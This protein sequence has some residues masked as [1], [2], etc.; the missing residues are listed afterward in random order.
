M[1]QAEPSLDFFRRLREHLNRDPDRVAFQILHPAGGKEEVSFRRVGREVLALADYLVAQGVAEA[2]RV[3]VILENHPRWG[4]AFLAIQSI[5]GV[6][7][8]LDV[9]HQPATLARLLEHSGCRFVISSE[10]QLETLEGVLARLPKPLPVLIHGSAGGRYPEWDREAVAD[11]EDWDRLPQVARDPDSPHLIMYTSGTTGDPKGVVLT[12]RNLYRNVIEA[13]KIIRITP[14]DHFLGVLPLYH[15]LALEVNFVAALYAGA[16][17]SF[18]DA[19]DAPSILKAFREEGVTVF[20]CVPQFFYMLHRRIFNE[21]E[22]RGWAARKVF[23]AMMKLS[24]LSWRVLGYRLGRRL[25]TPV[26]A[27]FGPLRL[28]GVGGARFDPE[29]ARELTDLGFTVAQA[30][31]MTET[32]A[33]ATLAD[34]R[35]RGIGS[36]GAPLAHVEIRIDRPDTG[37]VGEV[38]IRGENIMEGYYR[39]PDATAAAIRDGWLHSGDLGRMDRHGYLYITGRA[40]DVIVLSSGKNIYPEEVEHFYQSQCPLIKEICV[41]GL[42]DPGTDQERLHAVIVPDFERLKQDRL[43]NA[44]EMIRYLME[45]LS[46]QLPTYQ[47]VRSLELWQEPLPRT[48]TRKIRRFEVAQKVREGTGKAETSSVQEW[49][50][51]DSI[52]ERLAQLLRHTKENV[53]IHPE[54][55][56]ELDLGVDSLERV[57]F[58]SSVKESLGVEIPDEEGAQF[59]TF[60]DVVRFVRERLSTGVE[61][62]AERKSWRTILNEPL[63]PEDQA[64]LNRRISPRPFWEAVFVATA[65]IVRLICRVL[66]RLKGEGLHNLPRDYPFLICPNHLSYLDAFLVTCILPSRVNRRFSALAYSEYVNGTLTSFLGRMVKTIPVDADRNLRRALRLA[67]EALRRQLV[68]VVFPEGERSID[69][70]LKVFRKGPAILA[71]CL[72]IPIVP[73]GIRGSFEVWARGSSR[74]RLHPVRI[75]F[76]TP[77]FPEPGEAAD[78]FNQRLRQ[79]VQSLL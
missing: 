74:I 2:D 4:I 8:P 46:Q 6:V 29:V 32:A 60:G 25:F 11:A 3:G 14:N 66:F 68:L 54:A 79:A 15:I 24:R 44:F 69:G 42:P 55:N 16:R 17:S 41:M 7:V 37:G 40:K 53:V 22:R 73:V 48:T 28:F 33:L 76:G 70:T 39:N 78:A 13:L 23:R 9:L 47:R 51:A 1:K 19:L 71:T 12:W 75:R 67:A 20:V 59:H 64:E 10:K 57:E 63:S 56:L 43:V 49:A 38:L 45:T 72:E 35:P 31:G 30:Y 27:P 21:V 62:E 52:E 50:P 34:P 58:L 65:M 61:G 26:H 5:G 36:V 77:V 18:L